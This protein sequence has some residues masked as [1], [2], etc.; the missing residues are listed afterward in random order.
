MNNKIK[1]GINGLGRIGRHLFKM[2]I[3][4]PLIDL[5]GINEINP[6]LN[7]WSYTLNYDSIYGQ[8]KHKTAIK[9][10]KL[11]CN[12][13][14]IFTSMCRDISEVK[15]K[16]WGV[17]IIID[18][19]GVLENTLKASQLINENYVEKIIFTNS[20]E[21]VDFT[22]ILGVNEKEYN[23]KKHHLISSSIC[24]A[25]AIAPV[26]KIIDSLY[27]IK[28]GYVTTL[29]PWL[30]YQN[31]M[32]GPS[33]SWSVPGKVYPHYALGRSAIGNMIP[34]PTSA[35]EAVF[36]VL[37]S[38]TKN[39]GSFSYRTPTQ[40]IGSAD[41]SFLVEKSTYKEEIIEAFTEFQ[42][43]Q[44]YP[45]FKLTDE[46]LVSMDYVCEKYSAIVDTRWLDV[47]NHE[48]IKI[49]LWYDNEYGYCCNVINQIK[50]IHNLMSN[51]D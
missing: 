2:C 13:K 46:P 10:K 3:D 34:K 28:L 11:I 27:K 26:S 20:P 40:I 18:S 31:I 22:M 16:D 12:N 9:N 38:L 19:S 32:D 24:D 51:S 8:S 6:D 15:W 36:K 37:P 49:V 44:K 33:S 14:S 50:Y 48:L 45:I 42:N 47:V 1:V 25:T 41:L 35:M 30:S 23:Q 5:V 7:N 29:H 4:D 39:I 43:T 17:Q 21:N